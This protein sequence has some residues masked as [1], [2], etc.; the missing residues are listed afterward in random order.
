MDHRTPDT[1]RVTVFDDL[2]ES[3]ITKEIFLRLP[4][5]DILRCGVVSQG[6]SCHSGIGV[7]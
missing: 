5:K 2:P 7:S 4:S 6:R 3:I 1:S